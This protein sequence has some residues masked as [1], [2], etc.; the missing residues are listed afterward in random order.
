MA[1]VPTGPVTEGYARN[2]IYTALLIIATSFVY[3][4][5]TFT[6]IRCVQLFGSLF[7]PAGG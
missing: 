7:P 6:A 3:V 5:V 4:A 1:Q 2:D